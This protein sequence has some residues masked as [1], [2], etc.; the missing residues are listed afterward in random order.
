MGCLR[1]GWP[2]EEQ[3]DAGSGGWGWGRVDLKLSL[4]SIVGDAQ[5]IA[6]DHPKNPLFSAKSASR[7][8]LTPSREHRQGG[9]RVTWGLQVP[10][11][12]LAG[13]AVVRWQL[14]GRD[15][16]GMAG[17]VPGSFLL[18]SIPAPTLGFV[19]TSTPIS[20]LTQPLIPRPER[21]T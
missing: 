1:F 5:G 18:P 6:R 17:S 19:A 21:D 8:S 9:D 12:A 4:R 2:Q 16:L 14:R 11:G 7:T 15:R 20:L 10:W 3:L 13:V